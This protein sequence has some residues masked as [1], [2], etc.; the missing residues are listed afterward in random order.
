VVYNR[1]PK[2]GCT[3]IANLL[4]DIAF[5][6][7]I[8]V[9]SYKITNYNP[10]LSL[11]YQYSFV[12][13]IT[14]WTSHRPALLHGHMAYINFGQFGAPEPLYINV[15]RDPI[16]RLV[17]HYYFRR[18]GDNLQKNWKRDPKYELKTFNECI[19]E[20]GWECQP[21]MLWHQIPFLCGMNAEC[22]ETDSEWA[23]EEG[24]RNVLTK[25]FL[26]GVTEQI[27]DF[28]MVLEANLPTLFRGLTGKLEAGQKS[29][30]RSTSHK[31]PLSEESLNFLKSSK[32]YKMEQ[33]LYDFTKD[34]FNKIKSSSTFADEKGRLQ[35]NM[36]RTWQY[37]KIKAPK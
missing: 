36:N 4:F 9:M 15:I 23:L 10:R 13:N 25:Y 12:W 21:E 19:Q 34:L 18:Y 16:D 29:H 17:S 31:D 5:E 7:E 11:R 1:V 14:Q 3:T 30:M 24:K 37:Y 28:I 33:E 6:N 8:Y 35:P 32:T 2:T 22:W 26:V 27:N 20:K